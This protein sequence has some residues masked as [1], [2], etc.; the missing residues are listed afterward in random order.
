MT[1][2]GTK[3]PGLVKFLRFGI[4]LSVFVPLIIFRDFI[5]PFHF[6]KVFV[7]PSMARHSCASPG[8]TFVNI[9]P[10]FGGYLTPTAKKYRPSG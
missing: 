5:S 9:K 2:Q 6:G 1:K 7:F 8:K 3:E 4:Y 10:D